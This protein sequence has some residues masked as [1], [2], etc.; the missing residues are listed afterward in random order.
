[1][2]LESISLGEITL[3]N[4]SDVLLE[5]LQEDGLP[6]ALAVLKGTDEKGNNYQL[7]ISLEV[8]K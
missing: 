2:K 3:D 4:I 1:M 6:Y 8:T 5:K 7:R